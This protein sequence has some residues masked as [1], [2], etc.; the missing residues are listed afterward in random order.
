[1][2]S[3][4]LIDNIEHFVNE[5]G[6]VHVEQVLTMFG[7]EHSEE[8]ILW[9]I[10]E[11]SDDCKINYDFDRKILKRRQLVVEKD[12]KQKLITEAAWLLAHMGEKQVRDYCTLEYPFQLLII[13]EDDTV[14][15]V[16]VFTF[17][18]IKS[19]SMTLNRRLEQCIPKGIPDEVVHIAV[20]AD[21]EM[22]NDIKPLGLDSFCIL[23]NANIPQY[24][25]WED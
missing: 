15:D 20:V 6:V 3:S 25:Q 9:C 10:K 24:G 2:V 13:G 1:M 22:A 18:T 12:F 5:L 14:Y 4:I 23:N 8:T 16:T 11:L 17:Q 19:L 21:M 7:E